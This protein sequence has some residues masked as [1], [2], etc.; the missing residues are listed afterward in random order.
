MLR[1]Y[2][3]I[4]KHEMHPNKWHRSAVI[5]HSI[6][7]ILGVTSVLSSIIVATFIDELGSFRTKI[8]A[9]ISAASVAI[10][11]TTSV[12]RKGNGFRQA[13]R[14]LKAE[15]I[16]FRESESSVKDLIQAFTEAELMIGDLV[17]KMPYTSDAEQK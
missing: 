6:S 5:L 2:E 8:F 17:I 13:Q 14:H 12:G 1:S 11:E 16:R 15:T 7:V 9:G 4:C 3:D 10:L